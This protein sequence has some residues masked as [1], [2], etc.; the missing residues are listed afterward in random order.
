MTTAYGAP[1][2]RAV[3]AT[4][5]LGSDESA[6]N[7]LTPQISPLFG[8]SVLVTGG[9][10]TFGHA[11]VETALAQGASKV[12]VFSRGEAKQAQMKVAFPDER[13]RW[14]VGDVRDP[15]RVYEACNGVDLV[16]H[17]AAL[18]RVDACDE[19][20]G[21]AKRTNIDGTEN[22]AR[23]CIA[24]GVQK[25]VFLSTDKAAAPET[26]Y[27]AS[28]LFAER[29]W[30]GYNAQAAG[31]PTKFSATRYGN[32]LASTGSVVVRW[33]E[34]VAAGQPITVTDGDASRF[35]M[36]IQDAVELVYVALRDM[37]GGEVF[38]PDIGSATVRTLAEAVAPSS[39]ITF[40][41]MGDEKLHETLVSVGEGR[42]TY[43][44]DGYY[45]IE[46]HRRSWGHL[47][48]PL[49]CNVPEGFEYR[50]DTNP[51]QLTADDLRRLV[52]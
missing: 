10:G 50:S 37:R 40:T 48:P 3:R 52:A 38:V 5:S 24:R 23:A 31:G 49:L 7:S 45:V 26:T 15:E 14:L 27:G 47:D 43:V 25:A 42:R 18:K 16:V 21:E 51:R 34:Q 17:A 36:R 44:G 6:P 9:T 1:I 2:I 8:K 20:A 19:Q 46:P 29:M 22:V 4:W 11:F 30:L 32:V 33:R 12:V 13:M 28:K 35:W 39:R 41:G